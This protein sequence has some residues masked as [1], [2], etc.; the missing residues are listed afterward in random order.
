MH[1][2]LRRLQGWLEHLSPAVRRSSAFRDAGMTV[3]SLVSIVRSFGFAIAGVLVGAKPGV[4][5]ADSLLE[6]L[7]V[8][9][10]GSAGCAA[11]RN[12]FVM[13]GETIRK[14]GLRAVKQCRAMTWADAEHFISTLK[15]TP[16]LREIKAMQSYV[17]FRVESTVAVVVTPTID[18][19][20]SPRCILLVHADSR[21]W[22]R[23]GLYEFAMTER[24]K[25]CGP[26]SNDVGLVV[27]PLA[28]GD[29]VIT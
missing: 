12:K 8:R 13:M 24:T 4:C 23:H 27:H 22:E 15:V 2:C 6:A 20:T 18:A 29:A 11:R 17:E 21:V 7:G 14:A 9:T 26:A 5:L 28:D 19:F 3:D 1:C 16:G 10:N 25:M